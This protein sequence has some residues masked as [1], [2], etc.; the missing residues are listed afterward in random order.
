MDEINVMWDNLSITLLIISGKEF[1]INCTLL[2]K[3]KY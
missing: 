1:P 3:V 2:S